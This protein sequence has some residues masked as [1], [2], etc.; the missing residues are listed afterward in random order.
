MNWLRETGPDVELKIFVQ[1][2]AS[3]A[4]IIG[5]HGDELKV[6]ITAPPVDGKAN[7]ATIAFLSKAMKIA[8]GRIEISRGHSSRH[9]T[10]IVATMSAETAIESLAATGL[11]IDD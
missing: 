5:E 10:I 9:K 2:R 7:K 3:K 11:C 6:A 4:K 8:R 1:P